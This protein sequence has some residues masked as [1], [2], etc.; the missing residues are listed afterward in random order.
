MKKFFAALLGLALAAALILS[1]SACGKGDSGAGPAPAEGAVTRLGEGENQFSF[2][3]T[4]SDGSVSVYDISTDEQ[5]VGAALMELGLI[6]G[7]DGQF[8]LYVTTV[9]GETVEY[10]NGGRYWAFYVDGEY[11][12]SGVDTTQVSPGTVYA[13]RVE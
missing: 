8:G 7:E 6:G 9:C 10:E 3:V 12:V 11:A 2:E 13:F 4:F 5:T 1:M